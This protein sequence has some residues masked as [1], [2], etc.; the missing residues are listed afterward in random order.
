MLGPKYA[1]HFIVGGV[2]TSLLKSKIPNCYKNRGWLP[3]WP[4]LY[5]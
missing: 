4:K 5:L 2:K 3:Y 1:I